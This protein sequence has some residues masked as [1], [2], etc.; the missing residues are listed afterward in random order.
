M[1]NVE[2]FS[3]DPVGPYHLLPGD[4]V[5]M[6]HNMPGR[7]IYIPI[8][9]ADGHRR[10]STC[11]AFTATVDGDPAAGVMWVSR[12]W[13]PPKAPEPWWYPFDVF[14]RLWAWLQD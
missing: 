10:I 1:D 2:I 13:T 7:K 14:G 11:E 8:P 4:T 12:P 9:E 3:S 6:T 5:T